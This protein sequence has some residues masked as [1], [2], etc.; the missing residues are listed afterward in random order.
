MNRVEFLRG[1]M[2]CGDRPLF[3]PFLLVWFGIVASVS[4]QPLVHSRYRSD[5][6][7]GEVGAQQLR[8]GGPLQGYVQPV[9]IRVP[10]GA[11]VSLAC[12][13]DFAWTA[14]KLR[15]GLLVGQVYRLEVRDIPRHDQAAVYP[16]LELINRLYPPRGLKYRFP[17]P[18]E[19]TQ[20]DLER[21][22]AGEMVVRVIYLENPER[23]DPRGEDPGEQRFQ[24]ALPGEDP[25]QL[26]DELGRPMAILRMGSRVPPRGTC[27]STFLFGC[28]PAIPLEQAECLSGEEPIAACPKCGP[29]VGC[30]CETDSEQWRPD[31]IA[32]PWPADEYLCDGGDQATHVVVSLQRNVSGLDPEDT[33]AHYDTLEGDTVVTAS[34]SV[35]I[36]APR[37]AAIRGIFGPSFEGLLERTQQ[38]E[39]PLVA[40]TDKADQLARTL[41]LPDAPVR[42]LG[43]RGPRAVW[44]RAR[45]IEIDVPLRLA[46]MASDVGAYEDFQ[47]L[48]I[49]IDCNSE[50]AR[51]AEHVLAAQ[52]W[53][54]NLMPE[55]LL[56]ET[57]AV[58]DRTVEGVGVVYRLDEPA[59]PRLRIV[60]VASCCAALPG[61][62]VE[63]T[64]RYDNVGD[65]TLERVTII[66]N[67]TTR[68]EYVP[69]SAESDRPARFSH[70]LNAGESLTLRW[71]LSSPLRP[72][73]GGVLRFQCKVR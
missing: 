28:P 45:G 63:F 1:W 66:D 55:I 54:D 48:R 16:S 22:M 52:E 68:L 60:K 64:L 4:A 36:Y 21:A 43:I 2:Q 5:L 15:A 10:E 71:E 7:P 34:N 29:T 47:I 41:L 3:V 70:Q 50:K 23:A 72:G 17:I 65:Q 49:G 38:Y 61:E 31:G 19:I 25:L 42:E 6:P 56:G 12:E 26:A 9:E 57:P 8:R 46:E 20:E 33:V 53:T 27:D 40:V 18:V 69:D 11:A 67:L 39:Q 58:V 35:C 44:D 24:D 14:T 37:F 13:G 62:K 32:G 51:L 59:N 30:S 73:E